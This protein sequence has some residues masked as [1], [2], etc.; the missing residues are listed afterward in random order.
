MNKRNLLIVMISMLFLLL[1]ACGN[2]SET[3][4]ADSKSEDKSNS[5]SQN[6]NDNS[7]NTDID[8]EKTEES[9]ALDEEQSEEDGTSDASDS[10][11][12]AQAN[13]EADAADGGM[14]SEYLAKLNKMEE[15]DKNAEAKETTAGMEEQEQER[16]AK[17]DKA[18]NEIYGTLED[19]LSKEEMDTLR[20]EQREWVQQRDAEAKKASL[21]YEGGTTESLEYVA[22]QATLTKERAYYLVA[23]Y[24]G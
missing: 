6:E 4:N 8:D 17:W 15:E 11:E 14:K 3:S 2:S 9:A 12:T 22:T 7:M 16:Y 13:N 19:Q 23:H 18:L 5:T 1:A 10:D 20:D 21:K 24:M